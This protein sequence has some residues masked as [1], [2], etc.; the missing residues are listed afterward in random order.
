M[1]QLARRQFFGN[2]ILSLGSM[3]LTSLLQQQS[4][5]AS[6]S[7]DGRPPHFAPKATNV[8]F[9]FMAG[10]PSQIDL[11][12][13]KPRLR[14]L[15]GERTPASVLKDQQ[16]AF[17]KKD[18]TLLGSRYHF[19]RHGKSGGEVSELFPCF[20]SVI[21]EVAI[22]RSM[23]H[24]VFNHAPAQLY[25]NSSSSQ[26]DRPCM[27]SWALYGLGSE[28]QNLPG[29]VVL[30]SGARGPDGGSNL[31][32]NGFLPSEYQGTRFNKVGPPIL[33]LKSPPGINRQ[34]QSQASD[35]VADLNR[36]RQEQT[37]DP[38]I[39][40]RTIAYE[41]A[42]RMQSSAPEL[43]DFRDETEESLRMYGIDSPRPSFARNCLL[44][45]RLVERG[46]RFVQLY[47]KDW[48]HHG[49]PALTL[50]N[51]L[52]AVCRETDQP[53]AALIRDLKR[54]GL[55]DETL[56][57]WAGEFGRT[58]FGENRRFTGRDH[59]PYAFTI[60]MAGGGIR[61]GQT[62]GA[63]DELGFNVVED[64]VSVQDFQAT[65]LHLLGMDHLK[66]TYRFKGRDFRL[67]DVSG[68]VVDKLLA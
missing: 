1:V 63:T 17:V 5:R 11:Y 2:C 39:T 66:L 33:Y 36:Y 7:S 47:H 22:I 55:L 27:G 32:S 50:E 14:Q 59:H 60:W 8:I 25:L 21:D 57:I 30:Q 44:A 29:F 61:G 56:V 48:D 64:P 13:P 45:R 42:F 54:R 28:C 10:G 23:H 18:A 40:A 46:A 49:D 19:A 41:L 26:P 65:V 53:V 37:G 38:E 15:N 51:G 12:D 67:T 35:V 9:F 58:P 31:Y 34:R 24:H 3:A 4:A 16:F 62:I 20:A 6:G 68:N 52:P 43:I